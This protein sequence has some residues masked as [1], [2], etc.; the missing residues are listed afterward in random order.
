MNHYRVEVGNCI[1][2][3]TGNTPDQ[4][5]KKIEERFN[6]RVFSVYDMVTKEFFVVDL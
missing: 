4:V 6:M 1:V 5:A 2:Y 3:A